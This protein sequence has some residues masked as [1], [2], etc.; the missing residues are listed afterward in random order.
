MG[1]RQRERS[2]QDEL[3]EEL[4]AEIDGSLIEQCLALTPTERL[5]RLQ[6][7]LDFLDSARWPGGDRPETAD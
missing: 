6:K 1:Y 3:I 5:E 7:L 4:A 2:S